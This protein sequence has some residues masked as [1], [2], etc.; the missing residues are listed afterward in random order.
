MSGRNLNRRDFFRV[1]VSAGAM[2]SGM[3]R[4]ESAHADIVQER[5]WPIIDMHTHLLKQV[6]PPL[7]QDPD[8]RANPLTSHYTWHEHNGDLLVQEMRTW[9][10]SLRRW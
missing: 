1:S 3:L 2:A 9:L 7:P 8:L 10:E 4:A 6:R 5:D